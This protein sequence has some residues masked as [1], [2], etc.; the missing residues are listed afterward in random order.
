[1]DGKSVILRCVKCGKTFSGLA[2]SCERCPKSLLRAEYPQAKFKPLRRRGIFKFLPWLPPSRGVT[3]PIGPCVYRS[4][5]LAEHLG[6]KKLHVGYNGYAPE[7]GA[8]NMTGT[9]KDFEALPTLMHLRE[10]GAQSVTLASVG[11]TGRAF[12]YAGSVT[13]FPVYI[14]VPEAM[15]YRLW[16]PTKP[17]PAVRVTVIEGSN[18]Y[19]TAIKLYRLVAREFGITGEGGVRNV[20]RRD[21]MGTSVLEY[22]RVVKA[23]PDHYFQ[24]V[25]S[26][27]G[28]IAA[29]EAAVRLLGDG[30]FGNV[31]PVLHLSQNAPF[32]P[33]HDAWT[34]GKP[35]DPDRDVAGQLRRIRRVS[36]DVLTNR[37]PPYSLTGGVRDALKATRGFTYAITNSQAEKAGRLFEKLE[38]LTIGPAASVALASLIQAVRQGKVRPEE[39]VMFHMTGGTEAAIRR[40]HKL[41]R[42]KPAYKV[43]PAQVTPKGVAGMKDYFGRP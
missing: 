16:I 15:L 19:Y 31:L 3:T 36:A 20:A 14:I 5:A 27:T 25:G 22:A 32:T 23:L 43:K 6:L 9:F 8:F 10:H 1:M 13:D 18:D 4:E 42:L 38:G 28:G 7:K 33:L 29:W 2:R 34:L 21:G 26:G 35:I 41:H 40:D 30:R 11:N 12:A 37:N 24:A 17:S 39:S